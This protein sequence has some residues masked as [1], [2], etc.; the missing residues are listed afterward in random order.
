[1]MPDAELLRREG[2]HPAGQGLWTRAPLEELY[3]RIASA[4][5]FISDFDECM[6]PSITQA[7]ASWSVLRRIFSDLRADGHPELALNMSANAISLLGQYFYMKLTKDVQNSRLI[8]QFERFAAGAPVEYYYD[9]A[10]ELADICYTGV[11]DAFRVF[12][13]RGVPVGVISLGLDI[14]IRRLL[15]GIEAREGLKF[16]FYDCTQVRVDARGRFAGY[17]PGKT[18][19]CSEDKRHLVRARC[20]EYCAK[21][22]LVVGHDRDDTMMFDETRRLGGACV[23]FNPVTENYGLL[24]AVVFAEDW[25]PLAEFFQRAAGVA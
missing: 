6:F 5:I 11:T 14:V 3:P 24:D 15:D 12:A 4:D 22:P 7:T 10:D 20:E 21:R 13:S 8:K 1:M 19:T 2:L 25:R 23:G 9:A 17:V 18:Y 16:N